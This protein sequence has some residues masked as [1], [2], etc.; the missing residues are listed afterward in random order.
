MHVGAQCIEP[1]KDELLDRTAATQVFIDDAS[2]HDII[3]TVIPDTLRID[4][5]QWALIADAK[6]WRDAPFDAHRIIVGAKFAEVFSK[7]V[8]ELLCLAERV[9]IPPRADENVARV[10]RHFWGVV[11]FMLSSIY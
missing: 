11:H 5:Q 4:D 10:G 1:M 6:A 8:I 9:A 7:K 2:Q 3:H